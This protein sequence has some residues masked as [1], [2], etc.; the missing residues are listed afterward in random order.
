MEKIRDLWNDSKYLKIVIGL[1]CII[2]ILLIF[3]PFTNSQKKEQKELTKELE[4]LGKDFYENFY[5]NQIGGDNIETKKALLSI[6]GS[7]GLKITLENIAS[8]L[9]KEQE[10][11]SKFKNSKENKECDKQ[12]TTVTI[13]PKEP[14]GQQDYTI[15]TNL[16]CE[17]K[18]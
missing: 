14:Y 9:G 11:Y 3:I 15:E 8:S 6:N 1:V 13:F 10:I 12:Q 5:Y 17:Y 16:E 7:Y 2:I 18:K 4:K